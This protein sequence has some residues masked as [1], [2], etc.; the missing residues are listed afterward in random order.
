MLRYR[1]LW[2]IIRQFPPELAHRL[3]LW[4]LRM[5][6]R[7]GEAV[8]DPF[9]WN[10]LT[11]RNRAGV[12]AG[13]DKNAA[14]LAGLERLG[15][16]FVEVGT[17]LVEPWQ[18]NQISPRMARLLKLR[19]LWNRLGFTSLGFQRVQWNLARFPR[20][21]RRG[22][23]IACNIGPHP[24][25]LKKTTNRTDALATAKAEL[26]QLAE[27]L[28]PHADLFVVNL[29]SPN[30]PGLRSLLQS[31]E[32]AEMVIAP[33]R[34][35]MRRLDETSARSWRT[36]LLIKLPPEDE[37]RELWNDES[38]A[39]VVRPLL[40]ADAGDGFVAVNT[41]TR[42][43]LQHFPLGTNDLP[44]GISGDPLRQEALRVVAM[45]R[46]LIGPNKLLIGCGGIMAPEH[47]EDFRRAGADLVEL[48]S[49]MV[50]AG[51][52]LVSRCA[53]EIARMKGPGTSVPGLS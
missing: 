36:P 13:F 15:A 14:C 37:N 4:S 53:K 41:S 30:T 3:A 49:G 22:M 8:E 7:L 11:F 38:L 31:A 18:G 50:F 25:N 42:L 29:S 24:G 27:A 21:R 34:G 44:G 35:L 17:I 48:Y 51:P 10:G 23:V 9:S 47:A 26:L 32:L 40:A 5:P 46:R 19:G 16:G 52:G 1:H 20:E 45:L 43:A 12:A 39:K 6:V 2:P 33:I 28:H